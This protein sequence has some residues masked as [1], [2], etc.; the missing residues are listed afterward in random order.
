MLTFLED[1]R[2]VSHISQGEEVTDVNDKSEV[3]GNEG[4]SETNSN[5]D[6]VPVN[7][8]AEQSRLQQRILPRKSVAGK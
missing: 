1:V 5:S 3:A 7:S 6:K 4:L 8:T 2:R